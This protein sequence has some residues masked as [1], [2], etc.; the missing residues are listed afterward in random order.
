MTEAEG[1]AYVQE[2]LGT[3]YSAVRLGGYWIIGKPTPGAWNRVSP[4]PARRSVHLAV[5]DV[6][7]LLT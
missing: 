4:G 7:N 2:Q 1:R 3:E 5:R 6:K